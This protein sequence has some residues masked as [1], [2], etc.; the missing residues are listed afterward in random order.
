MRTIDPRRNFITARQGRLPRKGEKIYLC[1]WRTAVTQARIWP[2]ACD[3]RA[4][5]SRVLRERGP[6]SA[7]LPPPSTG[8]DRRLLAVR[9]SRLYA[10][11][12]RQ[13]DQ[14]GG[15]GRELR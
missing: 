4:A 8:Y 3:L 7:P 15:V 14:A 5:H 10:K 6:A 13:R 1:L 12:T 2:R 11:T 9:T